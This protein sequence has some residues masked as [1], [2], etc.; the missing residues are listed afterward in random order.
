[1]KLAKTDTGI[2]IIEVDPTKKLIL[3]CDDWEH[4][5]TPIRIEDGSILYKSKKSKIT[6]IETDDVSKIVVK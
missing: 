1:M 4:S 5:P 2:T 3:I 6:M